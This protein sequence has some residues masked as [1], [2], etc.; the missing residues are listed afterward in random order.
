M[1]K[2][3]LNL[4]FIILFISVYISLVYADNIRIPGFKWEKVDV[5]SNVGDDLPEERKDY[6]IGYSTDQDEIIIF[7]GRY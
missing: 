2:N 4:K 3:S 1:K 6:A 5:V 7:G